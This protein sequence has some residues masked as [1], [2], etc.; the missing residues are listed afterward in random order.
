MWI[1]VCGGTVLKLGADVVGTVTAFRG[2]LIRRVESF[3]IIKKAIMNRTKF[4]RRE[5]G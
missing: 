3:R 4:R 1:L 5:I 2:L